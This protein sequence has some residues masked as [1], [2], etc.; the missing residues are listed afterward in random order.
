MKNVLYLIQA[1][2]I[3]FFF[4]VCKIIGYKNSSNLGAFLGKKI[5]PFFRSKKILQSNLKKAF[6]N[7][8]EKEINKISRDMW[9]NYGRILAEYVFIKKFRNSELKDFIT[10]DGEEIFLK[11]KEENNP[12]IFISGHFNNFELLA[13]MIERYGI[14][15][16][17][18]YRPLNNHFLNKTMVNLRKNIF[19]KNKFQKEFQV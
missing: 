19:V 3:Y 17:A 11:I 10:I 16:A 12:V 18:I 8:S 6:S 9:E 4:F 2:S 13:M 14:D 7:I 5:G 1:I 15:L